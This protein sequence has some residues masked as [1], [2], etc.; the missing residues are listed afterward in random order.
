M[1]MSTPRVVK[2][3][4]VIAEKGSK[5]PKDDKV[6]REEQLNAK[7][8][9]IWKEVREDV[10]H[11]SKRPLDKDIRNEWKDARA[12][13]HW[14]W[15]KNKGEKQAQGKKDDEPTEKVEDPTKEVL[16]IMEDVTPDLTT[17]GSKAHE[18]FRAAVTTT[19]Q[20][21]IT[22]GKTAAGAASQVS[23]IIPL[24]EDHGNGSGHFPPPSVPALS[25]P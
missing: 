21:I 20:C 2:T 16:K 25:S 10:D 17:N 12:F 24:L 22:L 23:G 15:G 8:K 9:K 6:D 18:R 14:H 5:N 1:T 4:L 3:G 19:I 13:K 7:I 11:L